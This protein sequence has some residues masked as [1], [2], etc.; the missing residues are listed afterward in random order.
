MTTAKPEFCGGRFQ[1][2]KSLW[3]KFRDEKSAVGFSGR[4][5]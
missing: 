5:R 3:R 4:Q 2:Q 1:C